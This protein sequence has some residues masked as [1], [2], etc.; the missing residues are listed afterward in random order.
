MDGKAIFLGVLILF[1]L[2]QA[3][4]SARIRKIA[5]N[6]KVIPGAEAFF[7]KK[8]RQDGAL[9]LHGFNG[10]PS[11]LVYL[12]DYLS[13]KGMTVYAPLLKG[14]GTCIEDLSLTSHK[15]WLKDAE[16][17]LLKLKKY[18]KKVYIA[19]ICLQ[20]NSCAI[21]AVKHKVDGIIFLGTPI[22]FKKEIWVRIGSFFLPILKRIKPF[23]RWYHKN[24]PEH[25]IKNRVI[26]PDVSLRSCG[27]A[28]KI[29]KESK[30]VLHKIKCPALIM[31]TKTDFQIRDDSPR[32]IY[33]HISSKIKKIVWLP[34]AD[35]VFVADKG[36][37][38]AFKEI[39]RFIKE[40]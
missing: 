21:L 37:G 20:G 4:V 23:Y 14:H 26:Y 17:A 7:Y 11:E 5:K 31:Q 29:I 34:P 6:S 13:K 35:H 39:Y 15:D 10:N 27:E 33:E 3:G 12:G 32:Y 40:N 1:A 18:C 2:Y 9:L 24:F 25:L 36:R 19:G 16:K 28:L 30:E 22:F 38:L 8:S